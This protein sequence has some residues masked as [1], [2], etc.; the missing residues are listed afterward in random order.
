MNKITDIEQKKLLIEMLTYIHNICKKNNIDY[1]LIGGSL[2]GAVREKGIIPW[3]DDIDIILLK[4]DYDKL[5]SILSKEKEKYTILTHDIQ[6]DYYYPFA[7]LVDNNTV[8]YEHNQKKISNYGVFLDIF[9]YNK[10]PNNKKIQKKYM[11]KLYFLK[12]LI[13]GFA[14]EKE[15]KN[16][17]LKKKIRNLL[18][19]IIGIDKIIKMYTN[20][21]TKFNNTECD[22]LVSCWPVYGLE[23]EIQNGNDF[24]DYIDVDFSNNK[25]MITKKYDNVLK[26][27]FG[28]YMKRPPKEKQC[29]THSFEMYWKER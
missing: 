26:K 7:K 23:K 13:T 15:N 20:H 27:T 1:T 3:D 8:L 16:I 5:I 12:Q 9:Y 29:T 2:I 10:I 11:K 22:N 17:S 14:Y 24:I 19:N 25:A 28:D 18:S 6:K 21:I 4:D